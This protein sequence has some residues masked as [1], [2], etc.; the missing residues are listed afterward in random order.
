MID[1]NLPL[2]AFMVSAEGKSATAHAHTQTEG[3][4][5]LTVSSAENLP[6]YDMALQTRPNMAGHI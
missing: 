5:S 6:P 3:A 4:T 1:F 2:Y